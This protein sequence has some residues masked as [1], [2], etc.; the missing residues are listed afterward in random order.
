MQE[1][2]LFTLTGVQ[3]GYNEESQKVVLSIPEEIQIPGKQMVFILGKSGTGKSTLLETLGL[4]KDTLFSG[5]INFHSAKEPQ[6]L[7]SLW[8]KNFSMRRQGK[9][10]RANIRNEH[11]SFIFQ[12]PN[13]MPSFTAKENMMI[14]S[15]IQGK[16]KDQTELKMRGLMKKVQLSDQVI[17][18]NKRV[19]DLSGGE[20]QRVAFIRA[21]LPD[22]SVLFGDEPTGNLDTSNSHS[23]FQTIA[24]KQEED[25]FS[26]IIVTHNIE[27]A[28]KFAHQIIV[29]IENEEENYGEILPH[30][31]YH[32]EVQDS[33]KT[34]LDKD[35]NPV[36]IIHTIEQLLE[37]ESQQQAIK[38]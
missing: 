29:I 32:S 4:M 12:K 19:M 30:H 38:A 34:W 1:D 17:H 18:Q 11:F 21:I 25:S 10:Q 14:T 33:S 22:F 15:L 6:N 7:G 37:I 8:P 28:A 2:I 31:I 5:T 24:D 35:N 3:C 27:L 23:L 26:A 36:N 9:Q 13:L 16:E 20:R